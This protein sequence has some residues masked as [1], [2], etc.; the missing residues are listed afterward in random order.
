M[1]SDIMD[2]YY[3]ELGEAL[4]EDRR[5]RRYQRELGCHP[6]CMDPDH[7][8]CEYCDEEEDNEE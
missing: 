7:P 6:N 3:D 8:G 5:T 2:D 4:A 1:H